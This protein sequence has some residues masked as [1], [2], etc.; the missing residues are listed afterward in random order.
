[1]LTDI[2]GKDIICTQ[3]LPVQEIKA[4]L[5][6]AKEMKADRYSN[7]Y[8][9]LL[10]DRTFLMFFYNPSLRTRISFEAAATELGGHALKFLID[11]LAG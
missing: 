1:M 7:K 10:K 6:L 8:N 4:I 11:M 3:E 2:K 9:Q 5:K